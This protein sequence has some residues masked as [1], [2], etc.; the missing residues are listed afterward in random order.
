MDLDTYFRFVL[1]LV[2]VLGLI[3]ALAWAARRFG[4]AG[5]LAA[6]TGKSRRVKIVEVTPLDARHRLV[7]LRRDD[8]EH[9]VLLGAGA[10]LLIER[11]IEAGGG[12]AADFRRLVPA[13]EGPAA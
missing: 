13:D 3:G 4:L 8:V 5:R 9:L 2:F 1:A 7:L 12:A 11:G 10:D 6:T